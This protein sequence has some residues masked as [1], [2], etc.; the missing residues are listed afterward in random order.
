MGSH[1]L[2]PP[3]RLHARSR[4]SPAKV[5]LALA[6]LAVSLLAVTGLALALALPAGHSSPPP[7]FQGDI[8][9]H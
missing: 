2:A 4:V 3:F 8:Q 5:R 9:A 1:V 6:I 7:H